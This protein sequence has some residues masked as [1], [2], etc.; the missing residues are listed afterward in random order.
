VLEK[1]A[2]TKP[3]PNAIAIVMVP[4]RFIFTSLLFLAYEVSCRIW[5]ED[6]T[7]RQKAIHPMRLYL[8]QKKIPRTS[9]SLEVSAVCL[10]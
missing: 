10:A 7:L 5:I 1:P 2:N 4:K 8:P 9:I 6:T 3:N